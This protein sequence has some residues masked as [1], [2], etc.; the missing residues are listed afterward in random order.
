VREECERLGQVTNVVLYDQEPEG[1]MTVK[2]KDP[3]SAQACILRMNGRFFSGRR[4]I[5]EL[6]NGRQRFKRSTD[7]I[8]DDAESAEKQRLDDFANWLM[9]EE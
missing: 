9:A 5:A 6:Y 7:V 1:V 4:I 3:I 8:G 2:F